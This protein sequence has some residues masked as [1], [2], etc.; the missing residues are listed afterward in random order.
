LTCTIK[1]IVEGISS[2]ETALL[3]ISWKCLVCESQKINRSKKLGGRKTT[4]LSVH[5]NWACQVHTHCV[6]LRVEDLFVYAIS[7]WTK[8][9]KKISFKEYLEIMLWITYT[10]KEN[11][12]IPG[13][14]H[15]DV[16]SNNI[17]MTPKDA[18]KVKSTK[19]TRWDNAE[20]HLWY[21]TCNKEES[22]HA[23]IVK[24]TFKCTRR[25]HSNY[26]FQSAIFQTNIHGRI[27]CHTTLMNFFFELIL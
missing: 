1:R 21:N 6:K 10:S 2:Y 8:W 18:L 14:F 26:L 23:L 11:E 7:A 9:L 16:I 17:Q 27:N 25:N 13:K 4:W 15:V 3:W 20:K 5:Y 22:I 19:K 12:W 24:R